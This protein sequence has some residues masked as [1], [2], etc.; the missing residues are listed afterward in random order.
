MSEDTTDP[1]ESPDDEG[2]RGAQ[3]KIVFYKRNEGGEQPDSGGQ[4]TPGPSQGPAGVDP[5][6][7]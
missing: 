7:E 1:D 6:S 4:E 5:P 2:E 3:N